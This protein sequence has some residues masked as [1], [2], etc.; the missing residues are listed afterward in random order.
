VENVEY[1]SIYQRG[2]SLLV[3]NACIGDSGLYKERE[4]A[5]Q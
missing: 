5:G 4:T 1:D 2:I 3:W